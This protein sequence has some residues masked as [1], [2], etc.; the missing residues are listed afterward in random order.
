M[1]GICNLKRLTQIVVLQIAVTILVD[2]NAPFSA[3]CLG[4]EDSCSGKT[5]W[6]VLDKLHVFECHPSPIGHG[7]CISGLN[8]P[9]CRE[10]E[11][12]S[13]ASCTDNNGLTGN[14]SYLTRAQF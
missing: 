5:S 2:S 13:C 11:N 4:N 3:S 14:N 1:A 6:M 8:R 12:A 7:H 10:W 9:I